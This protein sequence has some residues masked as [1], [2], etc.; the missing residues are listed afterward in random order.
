[1]SALGLVLIQT[2]TERQQKFFSGQPFVVIWVC[3]ALAA[4]MNAAM[5]WG[6]F[7]VFSGSLAPALPLLVNVASSVAVFPLL[8][9][10]FS[11]VVKVLARR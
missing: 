2:I 8:A 1:M 7:Y 9:P 3:F 11:V 6:I 10:L 5:Q 4:F